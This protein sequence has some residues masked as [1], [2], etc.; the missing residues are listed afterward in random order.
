MSNTAAMRVGSTTFLVERIAADCAPLQ[1]VRELTQNSFEAI[2]RHRENNWIGEGLIEW[3]VDWSLVEK[4]GIYKLQIT[5]N[6]CGMTGQEIEEY[7][8]RLSSSGGEQSDEK[9]YGIGAKITAG[10][11]NPIGLTYKSWKNGKGVIAT[12]W[13]DLAEGIYGL[14]KIQIGNDFA[15][16]APLNEEAKNHNVIQFHGTSVV[17]QGNSIEENTYHNS[18]RKQKWLISYLNSRYF[19]LPKNINLRVRDFSNSEPSQWPKTFEAASRMGSGG[20]Q[21]RTIYGMKYYLD[22]YSEKSGIVELENVK[23]HW[24][25]LPEDLNVSGG[26]WDEKYHCAS[27][28]QSE[29]Y[30]LKRASEARSI[31]I[32]FGITWGWNRIVLYAEPNVKKIPVITDISR[33]SLQ[34][35]GE[36]LPWEDW[37]EEFRIKMPDDIKKLMDEILSKTSNEDFSENIEKRLKELNNIFK[38]DRFRFTKSGKFKV[39][40]ELPGESPDPEGEAN[41]HDAGK[42]KGTRGVTNDL[43]AAF[44]N[45]DGQVGDK[46]KGENKLPKVVWVSA[47]NGTRAE[48]DLEDRAARYVAR[49]N[50]IT[51]NADFRFFEAYIEALKLDYPHAGVE[52]IK[53]VLH[54]WVEMQLIESVMGIQSLQGSPTWSDANTLDEALSEVA[55]TTAVMPR[56][57]TYSQIKRNLSQKVGAISSK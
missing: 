21:M 38:I 28:Y 24:F 1:W 4:A 3:D 52:H 40:G 31:L 55:L 18:S 12:L 56:Y 19:E 49:D 22:K 5:D 39:A 23:I 2:L 20:S 9:N 36:S 27:I 43:F 42:N 34:S 33:K 47:L 10:V 50:L 46:Q 53:S 8:N 7:I 16:F 35:N 54:E 29:L 14:K 26:V 45:D 41:K 17:L 51:A 11:Q 30:D 25:I 37:A 13:K 32:N 57:A 6:G 48:N 15:S 44:I